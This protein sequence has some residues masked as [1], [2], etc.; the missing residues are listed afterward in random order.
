MT[1]VDFVICHRIGSL[2]KLYS[3]T[4]T[5][6][7]NFKCLKYVQFFCF[8]MLPEAKII[9]KKYSNTHSKNLCDRTGYVSFFLRDLDLH[10][11]GKKLKILIYRKR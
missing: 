11:Q 6:I 7:F 10:F 3:V 5:Y 4:L 8:R 9:R 1:F 2:K